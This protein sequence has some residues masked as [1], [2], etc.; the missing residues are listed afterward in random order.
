MAWFE[1][2]GWS[3]N[4][5][6]VRP[7]SALVGLET[8]EEQLQ[9]HIEKGEV[10]FLNGLTGSGKS[11]LLKRVQERMQDYSFIYLDA[12]DLPPGFNLEEELKKKRSFF[13]MIT[14]KKFPSKQPIL[15]IDEFQDTDPN[16]VLEARGK[17][18]NSYERRINGIII[19]QIARTLKNVTPSFKERLGNRVIQTKTLDDDEMKEILRLRLNSDRKNLFN[20]LHSETLNLLVACAD[21]NPRKLLEFTDYIF[22][23]HA[24]KFGDKNPLLLNRTYLVTYWGAR[25]ILGLYGINVNQYRY[26]EKKGKRRTYKSFERKFKKD[27]RE[28][29]LFLLP[30]PRTYDD[31]ASK[32]DITDHKIRAFVASLKKKGAIVDSGKKDRKKLF[33]VSNH[34]KRLTVKV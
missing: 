9:N 32:F 11:S 21:G 13:D 16:L 31:M 15:I 6:D 28:L 24:R 4:P 10:C 19:A 26:L 29:L 27:E 5:L 8:Q 12:Q 7:N 20:K 18:E 1:D 3:E 22:D 17:W 23:F 25:E 34:V 14:F 33:A 30:Q 2:F